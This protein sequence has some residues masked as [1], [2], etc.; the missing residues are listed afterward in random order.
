MEIRKQR[1]VLAIMDGVG[2]GA[3]PDAAEYGDQDA[4]SLLHCSQR[5]GGLPLPNL[6]QLGLGR[7]AAR[8]G[9][10][11]AERPR[12]HVGVMQEA[13][14]GKDTLTGHW[15][16]MG[17][18]LSEPFP[19]FP[20]GLPREILAAFAEKTGWEPLGGQAASGTQIIEELGEE[21][22]QTGRPIVYT[23][24]D[25]VFQIAAHL[26]RF[27]LRAL[28]G[29]CEDAREVVNPYRIARVIARPFSGPPGRFRRTADR[30]DFALP[31]PGPT[32]L[33]DL[34]TRRVPVL[35]I[36]KIRDIFAGRGVPRSVPAADNRQG[37]E[38]LGEAL[39]EVPEGLVFINLNDFDTVYGHRRDAQGYAGALRELDAA[40]P[41]LLAELREGD[42]LVLTADHGCDPT[43]RGTDHTREFVP[44]LVYVRGCDQGDCLGVRTTFADLGATLAEVFSV[45][46]RS[47]GK[48]FFR[49]L[50]TR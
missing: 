5:V 13:S 47:P 34:E 10:V 9:S 37:L 8:E 30:K 15:E 45:P 43:H 26:D 32:L 27:S 11:E 17:Q 23:S 12:A 24:A 2:I 42:L 21:H 41:R 28:Y 31:P 29:I 6:D 16:M 25:S 7:I 18:V 20:Q 22:L 38:R 33:D 49:F 14:P 39:E 36:G 50:Q 44:L 46:W 40:L 35:G 4:N 19:T 3:L 48:S 1:A